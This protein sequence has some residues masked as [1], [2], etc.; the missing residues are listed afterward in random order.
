M[1]YQHIKSH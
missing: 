1:T